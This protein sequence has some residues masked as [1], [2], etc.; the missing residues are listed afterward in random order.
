MKHSVKKVN[1]GVILCRHCNALIDTVDTNRIATFYGVCNQPE[2]RQQRSATNA[3]IRDVT[4][5]E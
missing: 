1:M 5:E 2:C 3:S 4:E